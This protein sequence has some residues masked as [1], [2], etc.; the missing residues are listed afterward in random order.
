MTGRI[1]QGDCL[2]EMRKLP[3]GRFKA[4]V[5]SPPYNLRNSSGNGIKDPRG[6]K[7]PRTA[8]KDGYECHSDDMPHDEYVSWQRDC[9]SE[10]MRVLRDDG[11]VFYNHKWRVQNG[12]M[13]DRHDIV[14]GFPVR[15]IIIWHRAGGINFNPGFF[16]P[17]YEVIYMICKPGFK[18]VKGMNRLGCVWRINQE[19]RNS[20]PA[21]FPVELPRR[22]LQSVGEGPVLDPFMGS[23]TTAVAAEELGME[24]VGIELS[25]R[26]ADMA[27]ERLEL[28]RAMTLINTRT[29]KREVASR[30]SHL[31]H[32]PGHRL[33]VPSSGPGGTE[34]V[35]YPCPSRSLRAGLGHG[36]L[37]QADSKGK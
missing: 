30:P 28:T 37:R 11:V 32:G 20:H 17:N 24:W 2:E 8:L 14:D 3:S 23:G 15:Q 1:I 18:L 29:F 21:P 35:H 19:M 7:W 9:L 27:R 22:C 34:I 33:P 31:L 13:Q 10:M 16:L 5:T 6:H 12:M 36:Q 26:Y 25:E 4:V